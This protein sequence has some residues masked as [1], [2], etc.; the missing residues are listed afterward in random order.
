MEIDKGSNVEER[1]K[2]ISSESCSDLKLLDE[3]FYVP[4]EGYTIV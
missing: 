3:G 1:E 4:F 2:G